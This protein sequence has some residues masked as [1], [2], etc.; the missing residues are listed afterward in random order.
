MPLPSLKE[1]R[2]QFELTIPSTGKDVTFC[3]FT[4]EEQ[5][6]LLVALEDGEEKNMLAALVQIIKNCAITPINIDDLAVF[7]LEYIFLQ[8]R[9]KSMNKQIEQTYVCKNK[10]S[11]TAEE[12]QERPKNKVIKENDEFFVL[13]D[14]Q[15]PFKLDVDDIKVQFNPDHKKQLLLTENLGINMKY[16]NFKMAKSKANKK[17]V[18]KPAIVS[19]LEEMAGCIESVFDE[20]SVHTNFTEKDM[21][22]WVM[23]FTTPQFEQLQDFFETMPKLAHNIDFVCPNCGFSHIIHIEG[24]ESFFA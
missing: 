13:C 7:D 15:V 24:L 20:T 16:P 14:T 10:I 18:E 17:S 21:Y 5:T 19:T 12:A 22:N 9:S 3:H 4:V 11:I 8:L 6:I 2:P 23:S 1:L